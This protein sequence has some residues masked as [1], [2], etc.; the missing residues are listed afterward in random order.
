MSEIKAPERV[1]AASLP[2]AM[3]VQGTQLSDS[4]VTVSPTQ[5][6]R[7]GRTTLRSAFQALVALAA[8]A[9]ILVTQAGLDTES[10]PW[11]VIPLGIA[12]ALTRL[13]ATP[14]VEEF[15]RSFLPFLAAAPDPTKAARR[16]SEAGLTETALVLLVVVVVVVLLI[17]FLPLHR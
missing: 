6:R 14:Q 8:L 7:P 3:S 1:A 16:R 12:A 9:P 5:V 15:L 13:M 17:V 11:L 10:L 4:I 2:P